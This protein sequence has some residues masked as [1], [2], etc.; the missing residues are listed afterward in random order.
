MTFVWSFMSGDESPVY[1]TPISARVGHSRSFGGSM[2]SLQICHITLKP[3][4]TST[5]EWLLICHEKKFKTR[6]IPDFFNPIR[7]RADK[8]KIFI[9]LNE[10]IVSLLVWLSYQLNY[11][12]NVENHQHTAV[13][14]LLNNKWGTKQKKNLK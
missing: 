10:R 9:F 3:M 5:V 13:M 8:G 6:R 7:T 1:L 2:I 14:R 11:L 12:I 4:S